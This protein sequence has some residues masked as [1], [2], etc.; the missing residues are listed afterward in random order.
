MADASS[1][2]LNCPPQWSAFYGDPQLA[3][4]YFSRLRWHA[5]AGQILTSRRPTWKGGKGTIS[6]A[7]VHSSDPELFE[8]M[9]GLA[10]SLALALEMLQL[11]TEKDIDLI[12]EALQPGIDTQ[13]VAAN[14]MRDWFSAPACRW[15]ELIGD[16]QVDDLRQQWIEACGHWLEDRRLSD[17]SEL[18]DR[19]HGLVQPSNPLRTV[20]NTILE[21]LIAMS[22]PPTGEDLDLWR[23]ITLGRGIHSKFMVAQFALGWT[24]SDFAKETELFSWF[25]ERQKK[26]PGGQFTE[27]T[28]RIAQ[29]EWNQ[30]PK[31]AKYIAKEEYFFEHINSALSPIN[32]Q[33]CNIM[34]SR[35]DSAPRI[36]TNL[37]KPAVA[38]QFVE[39]EL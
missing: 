12:A 3:Q 36:G 18:T 23:S 37:Q 2:N 24:A 26:E 9:T 34:K 8:R 4:F 39:T 19:M 29:E 17:F 7:M 30:L 5:K 15:P 6:A 28:L 21:S 10:Y 33:L 25:T 38:S 20:Q 31:D 22:P 1:L 16:K 11:T 13:D 27:A 32:E 35:L 14:V